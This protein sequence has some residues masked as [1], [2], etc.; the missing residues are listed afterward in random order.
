MRPTV[1]AVHT[2]KN[3]KQCIFLRKLNK[4]LNINPLLLLFPLLF[5]LFFPLLSLPFLLSYLLLLMI[6]VDIFVLKLLG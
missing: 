1:Q 6:V 2:K 3:Y 5:S 4:K